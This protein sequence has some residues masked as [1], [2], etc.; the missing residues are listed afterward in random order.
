MLI[1]SLN[2]SFH[3]LWTKFKNVSK[4]DFINKKYFRPQCRIII[5]ESK[6]TIS[7]TMVR[8]LRDHPKKVQ[9]NNLSFTPENPFEILEIT[10]L[11]EIQELIM[12]HSRQYKYFGSCAY[13]S[14]CGSGKTLAGL[15]ITHKLKGKTL[16]ISARNAVN[17]Q[18]IKT[19]LKLYPTSIVSSDSK[20]IENADFWVYTPQFLVNKLEKQTP[21]NIKPDIIIYDEVHSLLSNEFFKIIKYPIVQVVNKNW[22]ELPYM[23]ALSA[24]YPIDDK[25]SMN[26]VNKIFGCVYN[27]NSIITDIPVTVW[28]Y[29]DHYT[30]IFENHETGGIYTLTHKRGDIL[31]GED[32]LG[33]FDSKY[34]PLND[35]EFIEHIIENILK[36]NPEEPFN[37][38]EISQ[39]F[40]GIIMTH[41]IDASVYTM[42]YVK[43]KLNCSVYLVRAAHENDYYIDESTIIPDI[44][45]SF[46][47]EDLGKVYKDIGV[48]KLKKN[49]INDEYINKSHIIVGTVARL[50]EGFSVE[51]IVWGLCSSFM[52]SIIQRTQLLGRCRRLSSDDEINKHERIMFVCSGTIPSNYKNPYRIRR[53]IKPTITYN[54]ELEKSIYKNENYIKI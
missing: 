17:D 45:K 14:P 48:I 9:T 19:I 16:I 2:D 53:K 42:L 1:M 44:D 50:K 30:R 39:K 41:S 31:S 11:T 49:S 29:R 46:S 10:K 51:N 22:D 4:N 7:K 28:D 25:N 20:I 36:E 37:K 27:V 33:K 38:I 35:Y 24:T 32:A 6:A 43:N 15:Y 8:L 54:V 21:I 40:K 18:W 3:D 12:N 52:Y 47:L 13:I 5:E 34:T 26:I 23:F